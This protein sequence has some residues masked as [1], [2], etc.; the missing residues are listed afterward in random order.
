[1][2]ECSTPEQACE[3][4]LRLAGGDDAILVAGSLYVVGAA[5][6]ALKRLMP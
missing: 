4:A 6:P 2:I 1:V 3:R 5:R